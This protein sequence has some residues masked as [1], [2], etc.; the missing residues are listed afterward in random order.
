MPN[1]TLFGKEARDKLLIGMDTVHDV[2][3]PTL[4][5][6]G[7]NGA[8]QRFGRPKI[9]NDGV[10]LARA[11]DPI[12]PFEKMGADFIKEAAEKTNSL[13]GD[14]TTTAIVL[15]RA[16]IQQGLEKV[17]VGVNPTILR[18]EMEE[19]G[20]KV[21]EELTKIA[22]PIKTHEELI[23]V[24]TISVENPKLGTMIADAV[25]LAGEDGRV[26]VEES[27]LPG[28]EVEE[29]NGYT[30]DKSYVSPYMVSDPL[31][32][33]AELKTPRILVTDRSFN[34]VNDLST[35]MESMAAKGEM[36]LLIIAEEVVGGALELCVMNHL[37]GGFHAV[38]VKRPYDKNALEDIAA[39]TGATMISK[40]KG[41]TTITTDKLGSADKVIVTDTSTS[42]I[43]PHG[44][45]LEGAKEALRVQIKASEDYEKDKLEV[46][47]AALNGKSAIIKVGAS[48]ETEMRH[49]K[50][51]I[52][53]AVN[54][55][56]AAKDGIIPGGGT[57]LARIASH[58]F[59]LNPND[60]EFVVGT[61]LCYPYKQIL[62]NAGTNVEERAFDLNIKAKSGYDALLG[63]DVPDLIE[64]GIVDP[65]KVTKSAFQN[66]LSLAAV[67]IT[68]ESA[69][70]D[71]DE[72]KH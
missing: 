19:A 53:D 25:R 60:G 26:S 38:V 69:T 31:K 62:K 45:F 64:A 61:A 71:Y 47:L 54:A 63:E 11:I 49:M 12:D 40:D 36:H 59:G 13:A 3:A 58:L 5:A 67:F 21:I 65:V 22:V 24:A 10:S 35:L 44:E 30:F 72:P 42:I 23:R 39:F 51:K 68:T 43:G 1:K 6:R 18:K 70:V 57:T 55:T 56:R 20:K 28:T 27:S 33:V 16:L 17:D 50:D 14:G 7:R 52:D 8:Y 29:V 2:V 4:G 66:A 37:K 32:M 15:N 34:R 9:T 46:R 41:S 48:T